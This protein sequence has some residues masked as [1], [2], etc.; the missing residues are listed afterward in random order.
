M[1]ARETGKRITLVSMRYDVPRAAPA[2]LRLVQEFV[3]SIDC[4]HEDEWL[5]TPDDLRGW[6]T[7]RGL[8]ATV[9]P[10]TQAELARALVLREALRS[11]AWANAGVA[12]DGAAVNALNAAVRAA[13]LSPELDSG[14]R[15][16][17][18]AH[19]GGVDGALG[20]ILAV[21]FDAMRDGRWSRL[22]SCRHCRWL[23]YD[24]S[25]NRS[26]RWCSMTL[27]GNRSKTRRYRSRAGRRRP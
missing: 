7:E 11:L 20:E 22:K 24:A 18:R 6:L 27:C 21:A 13:G 17:L 12:V 5:A 10:V 4:E 15:P 8:L 1:L 26:A 14:G 16:G 2:P 25:R 23:F 9:T 3:N 19:A